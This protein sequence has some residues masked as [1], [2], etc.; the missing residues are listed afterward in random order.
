M[1][2]YREVEKNLWLLEDPEHSLEGVAVVYSDPLVIVR[3]QV[4]DAP[5]QNREEFFAKLL[6]LNAK[7]LIHGAYGLE[8]SKV[9]LVDTLEY[10]TLDFTEFRATLDAFSLALTQHYPILSVYRDK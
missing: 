4:M 6:E 3:I 5:K 7:D 1:Y 10:D 8:G 2:T 9:V